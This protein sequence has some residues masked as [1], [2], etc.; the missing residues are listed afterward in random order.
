MAGGPNYNSWYPGFYP[1]DY[2][3]SLHNG[4]FYQINSSNIF[5]FKSDT[6]FRARVVVKAEPGISSTDNG[7]PICYKR[8]T[9]LAQN[10]Q[11]NPYTKLSFSVSL[12]NVIYTNGSYS[13][14]NRRYA[15]KVVDPNG[16]IGVNFVSPIF[17]WNSGQFPGREPADGND[18]ASPTN[19]LRNGIIGH[20][21]EIHDVKTNAY[22]IQ[23]PG[24]P[25]YCPTSTQASTRCWNAELQLSTDSTQD[26]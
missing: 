17:D 13:I 14:E 23:P 16:A 11:T 24:Y 18:V 5:V 3:S 21:V 25:A 6:R 7:K 1:S 10:S 15:T 22:C 20:I 19:P 12:R 4:D 9:G 26:F 2:S 8:S